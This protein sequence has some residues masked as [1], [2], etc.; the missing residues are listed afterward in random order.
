MSPFSLRTRNILTALVAFSLIAFTVGGV[1]LFNFFTIKN[2]AES[3]IHQSLPEWAL[4][5]E[6]HQEV[7]RM[8]YFMLGYGFNLDILWWEKA[9]LSMESC[10]H[11]I[12]TGNRLAAE[13]TLPAFQ[14]ELL[15]MKAHL[16]NYHDALMASRKTSEAILENRRSVQEASRIFMENMQAYMEMQQE[17]MMLQITAAFHGPPLIR[18]GLNLATEEELKIRQHRLQSGTRILNR[19]RQIYENLIQTDI[20]RKITHVPDLLMDIEITRNALQDLLKETRQPANL[21]QLQAA[22]AA[23]KNNASD[24]QR[25]V[26]AMDSAEKV[27]LAHN[28]AYEKL[29][30]LSSEISDRAHEKALYGGNRTRVIA[31]NFTKLIIPM[32]LAG[33][34]ILIILHTQIDTL[35]RQTLKITQLSLL[36]E[37][38]KNA[39]STHEAMHGVLGVCGQLFPSD[40]GSLVLFD[41]KKELLGRGGWGKKPPEPDSLYPFCKEVKGDLCIPIQPPEGHQALLLIRP[42]YSGLLMGQKMAVRKALARNVAEHLSAGLTTLSLMQRLK[43]ESITDALTGLYNRRYM[44]ETLRREFSRCSREGRCLSVL[45]LDADHFKK[46]NDTHGHDAGDAVLIHLGKLMKQHVRSEDVVCRIGGEEFLIVMPGL[47]LESACLRAERL[48]EETCNSPTR[49]ADGTPVPITISIG[50]A[51]SPQDASTAEALIRTA[52]KG[53]YIAKTS[54]RNRVCRI[55]EQDSPPALPP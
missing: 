39:G 43:K 27:Y 6:L 28:A 13:R 21:R 2:H 24:I 14:Q 48:R 52:D 16:E 1:A 26:M 25:L 37:G 20:Q 17:D 29:L 49:L 5:H 22:M 55:G 3:L 51:V 7:A 35:E 33:I 10:A 8:G 47:C 12:E 41:E 15:E 31:E 42:G 18:S 46:V 19:G 40:S 54:G 11:T 53:L 23:L 36:A 45:L 44:E 50:L 30:F 4:A 32:A 38:L 9:R 34:L